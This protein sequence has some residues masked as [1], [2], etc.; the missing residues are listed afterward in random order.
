VVEPLSNTLFKNF[1]DDPINTVPSEMPKLKDLINGDE[2]NNLLF[3]PSTNEI[4]TNAKETKE[5]EAPKSSY[6]ENQDFDPETID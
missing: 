5:A 1:E 4:M 6:L 2:K 3:I